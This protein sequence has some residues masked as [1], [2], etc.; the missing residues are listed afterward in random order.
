MIYLRGKVSTIYAQDGKMMVKGADTLSHRAVEIPADLVVLATAFVPRVST[1]AVAGLFGVDVDENGFLVPGDEEMAP[2][3]CGAD[4]VFL[5]GA[6]SLGPKDIPETVAQASGGGGQGPFPVP[7]AGECAVARG[8]L[9][10]GRAE[11]IGFP[12]VAASGCSSVIAATT[13]P[14]RWM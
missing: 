4:G 3:E 2:V 5:A 11:W 14:R 13:S 6:G 7:T 12:W 8:C 9:A 10:G 1:A